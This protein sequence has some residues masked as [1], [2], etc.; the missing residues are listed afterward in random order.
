MQSLWDTIWRILKEL[1]IKL[2]HNPATPLL[3][4]YPKEMK[5]LTPKDSCISTFT[6]ALLT[7]AK[8]W[9][10]P[11]YPSMDEWK[12]KLGKLIKHIHV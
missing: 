11:K 9:K 5:T 12:K 8:M 7:I 6:A 3:G 2:P 4:I 10:Q 1:K